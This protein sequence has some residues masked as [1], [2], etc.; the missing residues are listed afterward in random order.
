MSVLVYDLDEVN[1]PNRH[2]ERFNGWM[3]QQTELRILEI[4]AGDP[5]AYCAILPLLVVAICVYTS[6]D[7]RPKGLM[8]VLDRVEG[9]QS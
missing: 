2:F 7:W 4:I 1:P 8:L 6:K 9:M 3:I 5:R